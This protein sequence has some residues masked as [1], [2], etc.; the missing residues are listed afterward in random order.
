MHTNQEQDGKKMW[1]DEKQV[2]EDD[3]LELTDS[4]TKDKGQCLG[5]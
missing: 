2:A 5:K 4:R 3:V 1:N